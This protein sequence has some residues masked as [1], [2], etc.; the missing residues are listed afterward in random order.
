MD[1]HQTQ[2]TYHELILEELRSHLSLWP[3]GGTRLRLWHR[4]LDFPFTSDLEQ[5]NS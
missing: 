3:I 4:C 2:I 5:D 1:G